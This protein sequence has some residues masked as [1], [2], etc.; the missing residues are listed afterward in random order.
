[1]RKLWSSKRVEYAFLLLIFGAALFLF[2]ANLGNHY[3]WQDEAQTA[4]VSKTILTYGVPRGYDGKNFFSQELEAEYGE[5]Y[6]W[7][8]HTWLP[9]YLLA[10]FFSLFGANTFVA[11]LPFALFG[12][13][14]I[15]LTYAF[16]KT[17]WKSRAIA[18]TAAFLLLVC[19]PFLL[20]SRQC[21]YYSMTTFFSLWALYAY[22]GLLDRKKHALL[23]FVLSLTLLFHTHY[24]YCATLLAAV[25]FHALLFHRDRIR[26]L[27]L[28]A[29]GVVLLNVPWIV[30]LS[31][32]KYGQQY[33][34]ILFKLNK[35][36]DF[37][38]DYLCLI[39][40]YVFSPL[41]VL[42]VPFA[43]VSSRIKTGSFFSRDRLF[44]QKLSLLLFFVIINVA[45]LT[46]ASPWPFF[47]YLAPI[48]P[49]LIIFIAMLVVATARA[50]PV[51][52]IVIVA[53]L[54]FTS[55]L[56]Y[57]LYEI[58]HD[59]DGPIEGIVKYLN[60]HGSE[61]DVVLVSYGDMPLKFY[62]RMR[63]VGG[64]TG[65]DLSDANDPDWIVR[66]KYLGSP[67]VNRVLEHMGGIPED[68]YEKIVIDYPDIAYENR[69]EPSLHRFRTVVNESRVVIFQK[70]K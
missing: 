19:V 33:G 37:T 55:P 22:I 67:Y 3:L 16:C 21:R 24:I 15:F 65:E 52:P 68:G 58:T 44:W 27:L 17:F 39:G 63:I 25:V 41:L 31:G 70:I 64:L 12:I 40:R 28:L 61:N 38:H 56:G 11:R 45:T 29:G 6:I 8:W 36:L 35:I 46:V 32:M 30:W 1:M 4:L 9:F 13:G 53:I 20:L 66:R 43:A 59:Y 42:V 18:A 7:K 5:N 54:V 57:F 34:S 51:A 60:Q 23:A 50:H 48:V 26:V 69:E 62:T 47:R 49:V 2:L 10:G 14:T